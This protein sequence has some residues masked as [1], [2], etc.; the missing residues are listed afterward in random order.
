MAKYQQ[1]FV[2]YRPQYCN[3]E[4][5]KPYSVE[6]SN[7]QQWINWNNIHLR[8]SNFKE[9]FQTSFFLLSLSQKCQ[10]TF[11]NFE[12]NT[13]WTNTG[14]KILKHTQKCIGNFN[15]A[16]KKK[17]TRVFIECHRLHRYKGFNF[18]LG[19]FITLYQ[20]SV[21]CVGILRLRNISHRTKKTSKE[22]RTH[23]YLHYH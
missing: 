9:K 15:N 21:W 19:S 16:K 7:S 20:S 8:N 5:L 23:F 2:K 13:L 4:F 10:E 22:T 1:H 3:T 11:Q 12:N 17:K 18:R 6:C 14:E